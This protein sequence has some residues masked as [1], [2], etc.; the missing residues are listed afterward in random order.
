[1]C[2][3]QAGP[4]AVNWK[5]SDQDARDRTRL[6]ATSAALA[7]AYLFR[8]G[9]FYG[10]ALPEFIQPS[11]LERLTLSEGRPAIET[12]PL[13]FYAPKGSYSWRRFSLLHPYSYWHI[14]T[15]ITADLAWAELLELLTTP[16]RVA[17]YSLPDLRPLSTPTTS[18][19]RGWLAFEQGLLTASPSFTH[20][21]ACDIGS[22]YPSVYTHSIAWALH[23]RAAAQ[24]E[25]G[26]QRCLG[27]QI[28]MYFRKAR[29]GQT[30]GLP[31]GNVASDVIAE[32]ILHDIDR[33]LSDELAIDCGI[34][35]Y[36]D[37]YR[38]LCKS[39]ADAKTAIRTVSRI[40]HEHY[41][42]A[43]NEEK[44]HVFADVVAGCARP[45]VAAMRSDA[46][47][48]PV[49]LGRLP[50]SVSGADT[51]AILLATYTIQ[52]T[53]P[54]GSPAVSVLQKLLML[55]T[56][57]RHMHPTQ[58]L[59][60]VAVLQQLTSLRESIIPVAAR[61]MDILLSRLDSRRRDAILTELIA[62]GVS[63]RDNYIQ[64]LWLFRLALHH[65]PDK[66]ERFSVFDNPLLELALDSEARAISAFPSVVG[67]SP[68]DYR[69][70]EQCEL[71][72]YSVLRRLRRTAIPP[73]AVNA[74]MYGS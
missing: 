46:A 8:K 58:I 43:L 10:V 34:A 7:R 30:N 18:G 42:L 24:R 45:W 11:G 53:F 65:Q 32:V 15:A 26:R 54:A 23:G 56:L 13:D 69:Q 5:L 66:L 61:T 35:R 4:R 70:L 74:F 73:A 60:C 50:K 28:D 41:D 38:I 2:A 21:A 63:T 57:G 22:F 40:V 44:N 33:V 20:L 37:D 12:S 1:M 71:I 48:A 29:R 51:L 52:R 17:C 62:T 6:K 25:R 68:H 47:L 9:Y 59:Q 3:N 31:I 16:T 27:D 64:Q 55:P 72:D 14:V 36:R 67:L 19:I 39:E 49:L